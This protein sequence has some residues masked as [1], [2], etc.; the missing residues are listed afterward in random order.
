MT[1][2]FRMMAA[3][4]AL[5]TTAA[6]MTGAATFR[7]DLKPLNAG[8]PGQFLNVSGTAWINYDG[9]SLLK[10][11][12][13]A[14]G[15]APNM[16]HIQHIH[17]IP[18]GN[19][20]TP[21]LADDAAADNDGVI[22]LLDGVPAYGPVILNLFDEGGAFPLTD[23][24]GMLSFSRTYDLATAPFAA[25][26]GPSDLFPLVDREFVIHG[27]FLGPVGIDAGRPV[28]EA[29]GVAGYKDLLPVAA[30]EIS[31]VPVPAAGLL[32][33]AGLGAFAAFRRKA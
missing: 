23:A 4:A 13:E 30:G 2:N 11:R 1:R 10:V 19:S 7:A 18:G 16:E 24:G 21:T 33:V 15:L 5:A 12:I 3:V 26:F 29:N 8:V 9:G 6:S 22:E 31:A 25:A 28:E 27:G 14:M 32:L 17:G 20:T